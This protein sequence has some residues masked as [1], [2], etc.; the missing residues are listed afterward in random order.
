MGRSIA[1][2]QPIAVAPPSDNSH[3]HGK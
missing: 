2:S 1:P 3:Q